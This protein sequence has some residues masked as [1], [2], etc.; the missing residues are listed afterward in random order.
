MVDLFDALKELEDVEG[1]VQVTDFSDDDFEGYIALFGK[2]IK[3]T[4]IEG[5][6]N[7]LPRLN[8]AYGGNRYKNFAAAASLADGNM[9]VVGDDEE[10]LAATEGFQ[11]VV[12]STSKAF[13]DA[14]KS[15]Y[16]IAG[17]YDGMGLYVLEVKEEVEEE[18]DTEDEDD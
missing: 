2:P 13:S 12:A 6:V 15:D 16:K 1:I 11:Y 14:L 9:I 7:A 17:R 3:I 10:L 4:W 5:D 18:P 8:K